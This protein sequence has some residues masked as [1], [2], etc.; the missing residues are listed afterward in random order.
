MAVNQAFESVNV[1]E[2]SWADL[3]ATINIPGGATFS[4]LDFE[5]FKWARKLE[6][7]ES[8]GL[9]GGR[10]RKRTRGSAS[11]EG[12]ASASRGGWMQL[13]EALEV[14]AETLGDTRGNEV[15]LSGVTFDLMLQHSPLGDSRIYSVKMF[16]CSFDGDSSDMKQ[17]NEAEIIELTMTPLK[18]ATK[19]ASGKWI[20]IA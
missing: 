6:R 8:R 17:G 5:G 18:I 16:G 4:I 13:T 9:S 11:Y 3:A 1:Q 19:S 12:A 2:C 20:V 15:V 10:P 7:G 14:A